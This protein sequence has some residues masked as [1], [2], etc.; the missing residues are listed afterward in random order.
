MAIIF[1]NPNGE[2]R[3]SVGANTYTRSASGK[4]VMRSRVKPT[5]P[6]TIAQSQARTLFASGSTAFTQLTMAVKSKW[7][8]IAQSKGI[9]QGRWD[10]IRRYKWIQTSNQT[11]CTAGTGLLPATQPA[12]D[13]GILT[14]PVATVPDVT[15]TNG[16]ASKVPVVFNSVVFHATDCSLDFV[17]ALTD[18]TKAFTSFVNSAGAFIGVQTEIFVKKGQSK[19][20]QALSAITKL[21]GFTSG[22]SVTLSGLKNSIPR[23][24]YK[25]N[26]LTG[27]SIKINF[28]LVDPGANYERVLVQETTVTAVA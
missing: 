9:K 6:R 18:S 1:A 19:Y 24:N 10:Y 28:Y 3:G 23:S 21:T 8:A 12:I 14:T 15:V 20:I 16:S 7:D 4:Q 22:S 11:R 13:P 5:N 27:D 17:L 2:M 25:Y 26:P